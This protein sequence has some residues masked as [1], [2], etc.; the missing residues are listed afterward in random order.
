VTR[1]SCSIHGSNTARR[2]QLPAGADP[3]HCNLSL[4]CRRVPILLFLLLL[5]VR[6]AHGADDRPE[7][8][9][10]GVSRGRLT[11]YADVAARRADPGGTMLDVLVEL[12]YTSLRFAKGGGGWGAR[13]DVTVLVYDRSGNQVNGD[14]WTIP[15]TTPNAN[16]DQAAGLALRRHFSLLVTDGRLRVEVLVSQTGSGREGNWSR[17]LDLPRW[18][19]AELALSLPIFGRS[20]LA[21]AALDSAWA[22]RDSNWTNGFT[23]VVRRRYGDSN[24]DLSIR[25]EIYDQMADDLPCYHLEWALLGE[26]NLPG[27]SGAMDVPRQDHRG[28]WL[29]R[30]PIDSL[31]HG[32]WRLRLTARLA[33]KTATIKERFEI[34]E[35]R[36]DLRKDATMIRGVL[37]YIAGNE[38]LVLLDEMPAD[39]LAAFW[40]SFWT[41]RDPTPGTPRNENRDE[42]MRRVEQVNNNYSIL[43][44]G[45]K[46]DMGRIYIR[47][48]PP[49]QVEK[50]PFSSIGPPRE[51]WFYTAR[52]LRYVF[53]DTEG[54]GRYRL[55][56]QER[57]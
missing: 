37:A 44:P 55:V 26:G 53:V 38:E 43:Q 22:V 50:E 13:F 4:P 16:R 36:L 8:G 1:N 15:L 47:Y 19:G 52:N 7:A 56:G 14:L 35:S 20:D 42:F 17:T 2:G 18:A 23:P 11:F 5:L 39:S 34:D 41:R 32:A 24:P 9:P 57:P 45:W 10:G 21:G 29:V 12:P 27:P 46:S 6:P 28:S 51:I 48:G 31:A 54:F 33:T 25:G 3:V 49:D 30:P 40:D